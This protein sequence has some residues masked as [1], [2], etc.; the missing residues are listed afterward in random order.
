MYNLPIRLRL[1]LVA[2]KPWNS[3]TS[4]GKEQMKVSVAQSCPNLCDSIDCTRQDTLSMEFSR[5]DYW[6]GL[7]FPSPGGLPDSGIELKS[8]A[9]KFFLHHQGSKKQM[10]M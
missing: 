10:R 4:S 8:P 9:G 5:Y 7:P 6:S 1:N 3:V 2:Y